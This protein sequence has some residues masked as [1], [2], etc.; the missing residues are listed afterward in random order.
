MRARVVVTDVDGALAITVGGVVPA[1]T[2]VIEGDDLAS[3]EGLLDEGGVLV[4]GSAYATPAGVE[5]LRTFHL[6]RPHIPIV[7]AFDRL[8]DVPLASI[9]AVGAD[10]LVDPGHADDLR[11]A[12]AT[13]LRRRGVVQAAPVAQ[14][15][16]E[17]GRIVSVVSATG[18]CGKTF[19]ATNL[20]V[21]LA[22]WSDAEVVL[23]DLDLQFGEAAIGLG[24]ST[25]TGWADLVGSGPVELDAY[26][27][28]VLVRHDSGV[29]VLAAPDDPV[30]ADAIDGPLVRETLQRLRDTHDVVI[31]D[32]GTGLHELTLEALDAS[33]QVVLPTPL[34]VPA[35]R[36]LRTFVRTIERLGIP[37]GSTH[38]VLNQ[39]RRGTG[40]EVAEVERV[41]GRTFTA[42]IPYDDRVQR[43]I[44]DAQPIITERGRK[45]TDLADAFVAVV[46]AVAAPGHRDQVAAIREVS[47][48]RRRRRWRRGRQPN[49]AQTPSKS[50]NGLT[51]GPT[52]GPPDGGPDPI[53]APR[54]SRP[55]AG[56]TSVPAP[57]I[58]AS[59]T[60][61][62]R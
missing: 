36:N 25:R 23:V 44:N 51:A 56:P 17:R 42:R 4:A 33:D 3:A 29:R 53:V 32:N 59:R 28:G 60:R 37:T 5:E 43:S 30:V 41:L 40:L 50:G 27:D 19:L 61:R 26:L 10:A 13:A 39:D 2:E 1:D 18:G 22:T 55:A 47:G 57:H 7:L 16:P 54:G 45:Q 62:Q 8:P 52:P 31:V 14:L 15:P 34:D 38:L 58:D 20:A 11:L 12:L 21:A 6:H 46:G 48:G 24:V 49:A 35:I 9:V